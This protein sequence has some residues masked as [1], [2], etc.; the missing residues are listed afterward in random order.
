MTRF[1][2]PLVLAALLAPPLQ[3]DPISYTDGFE[4]P[5]INPFWT[6]FTSSGAVGLT[7]AQ[8]HSGNQ[9]AQ[10][11]SFATGLQKNVT[12]FHQFA[13]PLFGQ[14]SVWVFDTGADVSSSNYLELRLDNSQTNHLAHVIAYD[15]DFAPGG[16]NY[17]VGAGPA[18]NFQDIDSGVDRT[19]AWHQFLI[20]SRPDGL[21]IA[22]DGQTVFTGAPMAF[23]RVSLNMFGPG[24]RPAWV[25]YFDD[26]SF[27]QFVAPAAVPEP[28]SLAVL[29]VAALGLLGV[30][31]R[32]RAA[33]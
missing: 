14:V 25:G 13:A 15:Y 10:F 33:A 11:T 19:Q 27:Q 21:S 23:D 20:D 2:A 30:A 24:F 7:T 5:T 31:R 18:A 1:L 4:A 28:A 6:Q 17:N 29:G 9:A 16:R 32:R 3:A 26:F 22:I 12:L 8:V